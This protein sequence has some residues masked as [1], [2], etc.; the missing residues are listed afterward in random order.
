MVIKQLR[1]LSRFLKAHCI[2]NVCIV[3]ENKR[4]AEL[5]WEIIRKPPEFAVGLS[6][7]GKTAVS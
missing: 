5:C 4:S 6:S 1:D 2:F 3:R 7:N